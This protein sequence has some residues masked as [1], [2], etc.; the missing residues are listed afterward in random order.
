M[1]EKNTTGPFK[2]SKH[3]KKDGEKR[4][5]SLENRIAKAKADLSAVIEERE[6]LLRTLIEDEKLTEGREKAEEAEEALPSR[7]GEAVHMFQSFWPEDI[8]YRELIES[9]HEGV[10]LVDEN[11]IVVYSNPQMA[12]LL[13]YEI[14]EITGR[15]V[16]DFMDEET[17]V[18]ARRDYAKRRRGE[19][20]L[21]EREYIRKDGG[22]VNA[23]V[24]A[25]PLFDKEGRF[26]G[27]L[28]G[29]LDITER[30]KIEERL[31]Y[32]ALILENLHEA[33][34]ATDLELQITAMNKAA[35]E[36]FGWKPSEATGKLLPVLIGLPP[37]G[38]V[39][40]MKKELEK[41][42][43]S[44]AELMLKTREG[45]QL[46][47]IH[48]T[49]ALRDKGGKMTGYVWSIRDITKRKQAEA[50]LKMY[51]EKLQQSNQE[52]EE[53]A[54]IASHD[55]KEPLR[56]VKS[57]GDF[58]IER[59]SDKLDE[60][61]TDFLARMISSTQRMQEMIEGLLELSRVSSAGKPFEDVDL[62]EVI[63]DVLEELAVLV[64]ERKAIIEVDALPTVHGDV[65]QM[66]Q[67]FRNLIW[68]AL[69]FVQPGQQPI[70]L[71]K[72]YPKVR[73]GGSGAVL[74]DLGKDYFQIA[75]EDNGIGFSEEE[76]KNIFLPFQRLHGK[77]QYEGSGIGLAV[78]RKIIE[79]HEGSISVESE[80][81]VGSIF[82]VRLPIPD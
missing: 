57:F 14:A 40:K 78:C 33:V 24:A 4:L 30:K 77:S 41:T 46:V 43:R 81:G 10:W 52:L 35:E 51:A 73:I 19:S 26:K 68:N 72:E 22:R 74:Y 13:G 62:V 49:L 67:L 42:G 75:V 15:P 5:I 11:G 25:S 2:K 55:L 69:K 34:I 76:A 66:H 16:Y 44:S 79:R 38:D 53:F 21:Y 70:I 64:E 47:A 54:F 37:G 82:I 60:T 20:G 59:I 8:L 61:E 80:P 6:L 23:L 71:I 7:P 29:I 28:A 36:M 3:S 48:V 45:K 17:A 50:E 12:K 18:S 65:V 63:G 9:L 39:V 32:Q 1:N 56:K 58:L 27:S 31:A